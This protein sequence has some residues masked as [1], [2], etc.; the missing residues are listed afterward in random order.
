MKSHFLVCLLCPAKL[1]LALLL[2]NINTTLVAA[3]CNSLQNKFRYGIIT[4]TA[5]KAS[6]S[7]AVEAIPFSLD[8]EV[9]VPPMHFQRSVPLSLTELQEVDNVRATA[10]V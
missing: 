3:L 9:F 5:S 2:A 1:P 6:L 10:A 4:V 8:T 7:M